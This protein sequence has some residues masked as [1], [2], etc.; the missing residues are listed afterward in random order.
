MT[1]A[2]LVAFVGVVLLA[3]IVWAHR[4]LVRAI[5]RQRLVVPRAVKYPS[6]SVIR[7][8]RGHDVGADDNFRAAL[9][10]G[11][12]GEIETLFVFDD[13]HDPGLAPAR[14]VVEEHRRLGR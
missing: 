6:I 2:L 1:Y 9:D 11:Y 10:S 4:Q 7:P 3:D 14:A 5:R 12:P 8:V 13:E